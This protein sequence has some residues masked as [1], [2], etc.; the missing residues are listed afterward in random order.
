MPDFP[1]SKPQL[2]TA[3]HS[4]TGFDCGVEEL[5]RYLQKHALQAQ[6]GDGARSYVSLSDGAVAGYY[7]LAYGSVEFETAPGRVTKG[8]ARHPVPVMLLARLAVDVRFRGQGLGPELLRDAF[9]RT[10]AAADIAGLRAVVV[11]AKNEAAK[12]FYEKFNFEPFAENPFRLSL[13][14]KDVRAVLRQ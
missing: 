14:L 6:A 3:H 9:L 13:I 12:R 2:L 7:T 4:V 8:L 11:D 1:F 5:N 10:L